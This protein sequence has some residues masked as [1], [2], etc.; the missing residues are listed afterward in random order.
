M[1]ANDSLNIVAERILCLFIYH[2]LF[3]LINLFHRLTLICDLLFF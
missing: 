1:K 3:H 2:D